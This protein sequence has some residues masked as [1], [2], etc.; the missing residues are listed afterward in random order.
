MYIQGKDM[1]W[2]KKKPPP[3]GCDYASTLI[4]ILTFLSLLIFFSATIGMIKL[5][6][7]GLNKALEKNCSL[8]NQ[9]NDPWCINMKK[10]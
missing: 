8:T 1:G 2:R 9:A 10:L 5:V 7:Q 6:R 4:I 3:V